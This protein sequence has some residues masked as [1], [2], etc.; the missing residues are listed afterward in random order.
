[1]TGRQSE[2]PVD[3]IRLELQA[4]NAV[5]LLRTVVTELAELEEVG[6]LLRDWYLWRTP[7]P[8]GRAAIA[9][10]YLAVAARMAHSHLWGQLDKLEAAGVLP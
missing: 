3:P 4:R 1:M 2:E 8:D 6:I 5:L 10:A 9:C 7:A